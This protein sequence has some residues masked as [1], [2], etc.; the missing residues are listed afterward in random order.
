MET[1]KHKEDRARKI[2]QDLKVEIDELS[3][4]NAKLIADAE[5]AKADLAADTV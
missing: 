4:A 2:I 5:A 1:A 3:I